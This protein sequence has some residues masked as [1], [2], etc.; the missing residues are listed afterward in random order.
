MAVRRMY[1][2][3]GPRDRMSLGE[4]VEVMWEGLPLHTNPTRPGILVRPGVGWLGVFFC[5]A[6]CVLKDGAVQHRPPPR[7]LNIPLPLHDGE[8]LAP[9]SPLPLLILPLLLLYPP[10]H[11]ARAPVITSRSCAGLFRRDGWNEI[12]SR[13]TTLTNLNEGDE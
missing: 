2:Q 11:P 10:P 7:S 12:I 1:I 3:N 4:R 9:L 6:Q 13:T 5:G 8:L